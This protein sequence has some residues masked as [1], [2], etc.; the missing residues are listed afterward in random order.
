MSLQISVQ[1]DV[2]MPQTKGWSPVLWNIE[3]QIQTIGY[4]DPH[5]AIRGVLWTARY[6]YPTN[7]NGKSRARD[8]S[9]KVCLYIP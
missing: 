6:P 5:E 1:E 2:A 8:L 3:S 4:R 7:H 9:A